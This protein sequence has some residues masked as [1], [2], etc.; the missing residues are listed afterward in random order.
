[1]S[2]DDHI[3]D[4]GDGHHCLAALSLDLVEEGLRVVDLDVEG[5]LIAAA[6][7]AANAAADTLAG[8]IDHAVVHR[9]VGVD[10]PA[11]YAGVEVLELLAIFACDLEPSDRVCHFVFLLLRTAVRFSRLN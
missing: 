3:R 2:E 8:V 11:E 6:I 1:M 5:D 4:L 10:L 9:V 7:A